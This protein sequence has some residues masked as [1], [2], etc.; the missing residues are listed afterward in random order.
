MEGLLLILGW[1]PVENKIRNIIGDGKYV[2]VY[3]HTSTLD[4][5]LYVLYYMSTKELRDKTIVPIHPKHDSWNWLIRGLGCITV[6]DREIKNGGS[7]RKIIDILNNMDNFVLMISPKGSLGKDE[8]RTG[9]YHIAKATGAKVV[10]GGFDYDRK[11]FIVKQP[12]DIYD[13]KYEEVTAKL[14][15]DLYDICPLNVENSEFPIKG[16][17]YPVYPSFI[18]NERIIL[19]L[20]FVSLFILVILT[21]K[22]LRSK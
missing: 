10:S 5:I 14:K 7:S 16:H 12:F 2:L 3:P 1:K 18:D 15:Q 6:T 21:V 11:E 4:F 20:V 17:I 13:M 19:L 22:E 8:W 9:F